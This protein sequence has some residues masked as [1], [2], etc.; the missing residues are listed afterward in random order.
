MS[1]KD[2]P[3]KVPALKTPSLSV[4]TSTKNGNG[5]IVSVKQV[6]ILSKFAEIQNAKGY[7]ARPQ[8]ASRPSWTTSQ[9]NRDSKLN[10]SRNNLIPV[11]QTTS[12]FQSSQR[13]IS[14]SILEKC[15]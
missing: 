4:Q 1:V 10:R 15:A 6:N 8:M 9:G 2:L 13:A 7:K 11:K 3:N 5:G 14:S 12:S